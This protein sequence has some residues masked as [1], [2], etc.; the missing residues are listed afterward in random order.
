MYCAYAEA[1]SHYSIS[2]FIPI[3]P[4]YVHVKSPCLMIE[5]PLI[6]LKSSSFAC[7]TP[8]FLRIFHVFLPP[9]RITLGRTPGPPWSELCRPPSPPCSDRWRQR[10]PRRRRPGRFHLHWS[11]SL[12]NKRAWSVK[13]VWFNGLQMTSKLKERSLESKHHPSFLSHN[14]SG[15]KNLQ[16]R[17]SQ[18]AST[19]SA[20]MRP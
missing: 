6:W 2:H 16:V 18:S 17:S 14:P 8:F 11:L 9:P 10:R 4:P 7:W 12:L 1:K 13:D 15:P 20:R 3:R 5:K 19:V